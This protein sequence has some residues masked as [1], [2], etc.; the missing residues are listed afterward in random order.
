MDSMESVRKILKF[1]YD[2]LLQGKAYGYCIY[3]ELSSLWDGNPA[4]LSVK[5]SGKAPLS[6]VTEWDPYIFLSGIHGYQWDPWVSSMGS[7][8]FHGSHGIHG[9]YGSHGLLRGFL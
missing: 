7:V 4:S 6:M 2:D 8:G 1:D 3:F 5:T 9:I